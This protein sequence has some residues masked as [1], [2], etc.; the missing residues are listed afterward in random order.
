MATAATMEVVI[1]RKNGLKREAEKL[2]THIS[3]QISIAYLAGLSTWLDV[4]QVLH[5]VC[6]SKKKLENNGGGQPPVV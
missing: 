1:L 6:I 5:Y 2:P 4:K 3:S